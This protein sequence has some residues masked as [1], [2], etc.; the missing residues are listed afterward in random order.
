MGA[1]GVS[2]PQGNGTSTRLM[3]PPATRSCVRSGQFMIW[4]QR[5]S[6]SIRVDWNPFVEPTPRHTV[7]VA[8]PTPYSGSN[9]RWPKGPSA[10]S[11]SSRPTAR[12][13]SRTR[14]RRVR[15]DLGRATGIATISVPISGG[16]CFVHDRISGGALR[17]CRRRHLRPGS[18]P[19]N[20]EQPGLR[21]AVRDRRS[22]N[23]YRRMRVV[24][25]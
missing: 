11:N 21:Q 5:P 6:L 17:P 12:R 14:A 1:A 3:T 19:Y 8:H 10:A 24:R 23:L 25:K 16:R 15:R 4:G 9:G 13:C 18:E 7:G 20:L 2:R 22:S